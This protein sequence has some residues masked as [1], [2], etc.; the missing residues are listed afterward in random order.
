MHRIAIIDSLDKWRDMRPEWNALLSRSLSNSIFLTWEWLYTWAECFLGEDRKLFILSLHE[1]DRL[2]AVAPWS[3][4]L[5]RIGR[6]PY[7][8][9]IEFLGSPEMG[10]DYLDVFA[11]RGKEKETASHLYD[12][13]F[14]PAAPLWDSM[15]ITEMPSA[16]LFLLYFSEELRRRGK[17][18]SVKNMVYC[19]TV[20]L[21]ASWDAFL[22]SL[23]LHRKKA[24]RRDL[25]VLQRSDSMRYETIPLTQPIDGLPRLFSLYQSIEARKDDLFYEHLTRFAERCTG[26]AWIEIDFLNISGQD[27]A[28]FL[29]FMYNDTLSLYLMAVN[30][31]FNSKISIGN[32]LVGLRLEGAISRSVHVYD[33][34]KGSEDY[35]FHWAKQGNLSL[36]LSVYQ[37]RASSVGVLV[38]TM[39]RD[40]GRVVL[41]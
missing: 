15:M 29:H 17:Y 37:K 20:R 34:L 41:R 7:M 6:F 26:K 4:S 16:S 11:T 5:R 31:N 23:S 39:V 24:F 30:K 36:G 33:F 3:L 9:Q 35:K 21:P 18:F 28:G 27:V 14:G 8:R 38:S 25:R 10:S 22:N 32:V 13:L 19:P 40:L 2:I 12:F 1:D